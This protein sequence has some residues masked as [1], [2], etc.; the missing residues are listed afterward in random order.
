MGSEVL[1][2]ALVNFEVS[3]KI[4]SLPDQYSH[5]YALLTNLWVDHC[6]LDIVVIA[7]GTVVIAMDTE[8]II[9]DMV[10]LV[11]M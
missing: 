3:P 2:E 7:T 4:T 10:V 8:V 5:T 9:I 11:A 1:R 6:S